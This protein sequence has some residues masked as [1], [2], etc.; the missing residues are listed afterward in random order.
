M[1]RIGDAG[2]ESQDVIERHERWDHLQ[3]AWDRRQQIY[4]SKRP[5]PSVKEGEEGS[6]KAYEG[7]DR[8]GLGKQGVCSWR[9]GSLPR[10]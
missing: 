8:A 4:D 10:S 3:F 2:I 1:D 5:V 6:R 7:S 9:I